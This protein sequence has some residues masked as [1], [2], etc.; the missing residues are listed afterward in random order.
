[1]TAINF[2]AFLFSLVAVDIHYT[3]RRSATGAT[4]PGIMPRWLHNILRPSEPYEN[5]Y[6]TRQKQLMRM[7][8]EEAFQLRN[9][10]LVVLGILCVG[11]MA[12]T[13][14]FAGRA[15]QSLFSLEAHS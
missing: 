5:Y 15:Y 14:Y 3:L 9:Q 4:A 10:T 12:G 1:M 11:F 13:W 2:I 8:A 7:E 6:R